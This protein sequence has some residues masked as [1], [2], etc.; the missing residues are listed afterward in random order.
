LSVVFL[1]DLCKI[2][3]FDFKW[4]KKLNTMDHGRCNKRVDQGVEKIRKQ[5][6]VPVHKINLEE[7]V[8]LR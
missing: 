6:E 8:P 4:I 7:G 2:K 5:E 3:L 1:K